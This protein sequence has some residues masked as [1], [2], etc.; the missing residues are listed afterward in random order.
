M[1]YPNHI[2]QPARMTP[3]DHILPQPARM[4]HTDHILPQPAE[5]THPDH[6]L[7]QL[8]RMTHP[9]YINTNEIPGEHLRESL[10]SSC[11]KITCYRHVKISPLQW[12]HNRLRLSHQ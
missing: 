6:I 12:L 7:P 8:A 3:S 1:T 4:T 2:P 11:V 9:Y 5:I 10:I